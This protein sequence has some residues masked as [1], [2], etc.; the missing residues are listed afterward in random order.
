MSLELI[1]ANTIVPHR[2]F[3]LLRIV[4]VL[5]NPSKQQ[6]IDAL[7]P[8]MTAEQKSQDISK[9]IYSAAINM[10]L[11][12]EAE[13]KNKLVSVK[14]EVREISNFEDFRFFMQKKLTGVTKEG[15]DH[16]LLNIIAAWYAVHD[17]LVLTVLRA[18][19][20][21]RLNG[22]LFG[23]AERSVVSE[24][25]ML[26][27]WP[28]WA[29]FLGWGWQFRGKEASRFIPDATVR[30]RPLLRDLLSETDIPISV[31][32]DKLK[33]RC[34]ELDGGILFE[35]CRSASASTEARGNR[36]SLM[37]STGLRV[38]DGRGEIKLIDRRD[39]Q[40]HFNLFPS[41]TMKNRVSHIRRGGK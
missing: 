15:T 17:D 27:T 37:L 11:L 16:Y 30:L 1:G 21:K 23:D 25:P 8:S 5:G 6:V 12:Q 4:Q 28:Y 7:Q 33:K 38:L 18:E 24:D 13:G 2:L 36:L 22:Q 35:R 14:K 34:P 40:E 32:L 20:S 26:T 9:T 10:E 41:Q 3:A 39:A 31:F 19:I 29:D